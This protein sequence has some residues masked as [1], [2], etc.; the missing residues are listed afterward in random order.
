MTG[1]PT[2]VNAPLRLV[3]ACLFILAMTCL[4]GGIVLI[5]LGYDVP[6]Y[7]KLTAAST[8]GAVAGI[9]AKPNG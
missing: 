6:E 5:A 7:L 8:T 2:P 1:P 4:V 9:L 3:V